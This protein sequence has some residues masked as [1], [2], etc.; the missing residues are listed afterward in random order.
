MSFKFL[1][2]INTSSASIITSNASIGNLFVSGGNVG[3]GTTSPTYPLHVSGHVNLTG[4]LY[5]SGILMQTSSKNRLI[6]GSMLFDQRNAGTSMT[7]TAG[8]AVAYTVD[9]WYA[10]CTG[11]NVTVQRVAGTNGN[12]YATQI[13]GAASNTGTLFGQ[14]IESI[15]CY[16]LVNQNVTVSLRVN[17]S[18]ITSLTWKAYYANSTDTWS[19]QTQITTGTLTITSTDSPYSFTFNAGANAAN[20]ISIEFSTGALLGSQTITYQQ[21]QLEPGTQATAFERRHPALELQLC[22]RYYEKSF[23]QN[24]IP[25]SNSTSPT[26]IM[27]SGLTT[28]ASYCYGYF[29]FTTYKRTYPTVYYYTYA[30]S[31][32]FSPTTS[33]RVPGASTNVTATGVYDGSPATCNGIK[34]E[35]NTGTAYSYYFN[36]VAVCE[37]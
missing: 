30:N 14:R 15:N 17:S 13:T 5:Q 22:Q 10:S 4:N 25:Q 12:V 29:N 34:V 27:S 6:N 21:I 32:T 33:F 20:G 28:N 9:R 19:S 18:S 35:F 31:Q 1:N 11:A 26:L 3:I 16:D 2:N 24:T 23:D 36:Y 37:L 8:S 7:I